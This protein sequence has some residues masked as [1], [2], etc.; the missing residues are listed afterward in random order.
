MKS[1]DTLVALASSTQ[2]YLELILVTSVSI[3]FFIAD[4][5]CI[6]LLTFI[7]LMGIEMSHV[8]ANWNKDDLT[9]V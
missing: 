4:F 3:D 7:L 1:Y 5:Y 8:S 2:N 6:V 9:F